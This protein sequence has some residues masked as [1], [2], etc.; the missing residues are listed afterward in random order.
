MRESTKFDVEG[1]MLQLKRLPGR[2]DMRQPLRFTG[3]TTQVT[4]SR[5]ADKFYASVL[6][7]Y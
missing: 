5:Q 1:G 7:G 6:G 2:V 3:K 4:V